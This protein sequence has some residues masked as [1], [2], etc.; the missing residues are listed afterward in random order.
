MQNV[1]EI[2]AK[3]W[4]EIS[5]SPLETA[6]NLVYGV[7]GSIIVTAAS[8]IV[9]SVAVHFLRASWHVFTSAL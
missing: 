4:S 3:K 9:L 6:V 8:L 2:A 5:Q 1:R 7:L